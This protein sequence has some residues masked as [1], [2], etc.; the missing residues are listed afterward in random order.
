ML[1]YISAEQTNSNFPKVRV[2]FRDTVGLAGR[3]VWS[4]AYS[5]CATCVFVFVVVLG[6]PS[7]EI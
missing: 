2:S 6:W 5:I 3:Q 1:L 4:M 7:V